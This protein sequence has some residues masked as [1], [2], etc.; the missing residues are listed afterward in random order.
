MG[1]ILLLVG[2]SL[3][4]GIWTDRKCRILTAEAQAVREAFESGRTEDARRYA[5]KLSNDWECVRK[6]AALFVKYDKLLELDRIAAHFE[7]MAE[8]GDDEILPQIAEFIHM[9][10]LLAV[11]D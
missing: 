4:T 11:S 1:I 6:K 3:F 10:E 9:T 2:V 5:H 7:P 8:S